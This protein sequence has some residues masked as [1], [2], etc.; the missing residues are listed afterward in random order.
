MPDDKKTTNESIQETFDNI[1]KKFES[2]EYTEE[3]VNKIVDELKA[4][5]K[6]LTGKDM[7]LHL[8][9]EISQDKEEND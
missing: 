1:K 2:G 8:E 9:E 4:K 6:E 3:D 5:W 7:K